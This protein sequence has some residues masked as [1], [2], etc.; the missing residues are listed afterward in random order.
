M[1]H[2]DD[3]YTLEGVKAVAETDAAL[4]IVT[5]DGDEVWVPKS[6]IDDDSEVYKKN[7]EGDLIV[8]RWIARERGWL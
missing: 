4:L 8:T 1:S 2:R 7:N 6:Q 3:T 5:A